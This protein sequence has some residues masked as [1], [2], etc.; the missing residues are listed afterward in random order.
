MAKAGYE[1][2]VYMPAVVCWPA[3]ISG[4]RSVDAMM[5]HIDVYS[6]VKRIA[7]VTESAGWP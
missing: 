7:G 3:G 1:C 2:C 5:G 6:T 4:G